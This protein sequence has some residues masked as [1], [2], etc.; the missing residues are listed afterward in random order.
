MS[1]VTLVPAGTPAISPRRQPWEHN[2]QS[3]NKPQRGR[4]RGVTSDA[5]THR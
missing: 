4:Q 3:T 1:T 5:H 2:P